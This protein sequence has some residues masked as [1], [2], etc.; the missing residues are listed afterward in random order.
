M[1]NINNGQNLIL[2]IVRQFIFT[3]HEVHEQKGKTQVTPRWKQTVHYTH[4][5]YIQFL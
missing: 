1:Q 5:Y 4:N 3:M 2:K